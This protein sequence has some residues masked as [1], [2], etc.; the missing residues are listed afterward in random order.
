[1]PRKVQNFCRGTGQA[2]PETPGE[3]VRCALESLA[4][5]YRQTLGQIEALTG[6]TI[7]RLHIVGGGSRNALLNRFA[8]DATGRDVLAGPVE[9]TAIGNLL[10]QAAALGHLTTHRRPAPDGP[11]LL[12]RPRPSRRRTPTP[13][14]DPTPDFNGWMELQ[15]ME[16][17][18][19]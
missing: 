19:S 4:L 9:A 2:V 13:G 15:Q 1:M 12:P 5:S 6:R 11:R 18:N 17:P 14:R 10:L 8:A 3:V 7:R 16:T